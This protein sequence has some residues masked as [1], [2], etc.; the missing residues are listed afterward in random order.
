MTTTPKTNATIKAI[1]VKTPTGKVLQLQDLLTE[2]VN[3]LHFQNSFRCGQTCRVVMPIIE[4]NLSTL[5]DTANII[6]IVRDNPFDQYVE[7][8]V[9]QYMM[10]QEDLSKFGVL[11]EDSYIKRATIIM[12]RTGNELKRWQVAPEQLTSHFA[13]EVIPALADLA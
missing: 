12:D 11:G 9:P 5:Q 8:P 10:S 1:A 6:V 2:R 3:I 7:T 13:A 4:E